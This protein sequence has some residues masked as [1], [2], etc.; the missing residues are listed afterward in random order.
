MHP[1]IQGR[2]DKHTYDDLTADVSVF[3]SRGGTIL[4]LESRSSFSVNEVLALTY[5]VIENMRR[6][7]PRCIAPNHVRTLCMEILGCNRYQSANFGL[8]PLD[9]SHFEEVYFWETLSRRFARKS[10]GVIS[11]AVSGTTGDSL[12]RRVEF[13]E[14]MSNTEISSV[15]VIEGVRS[16]DCAVWVRKKD[17][18][19]VTTPLFSEQTQ[20]KYWKSRHNRVDCEMLPNQQLVVYPKAIWAEMQKQAW[21]ETQLGEL[22]H[23]LNRDEKLEPRFC[24]FH[25]AKLHFLEEVLSIQREVER[26]RSIGDTKALRQE[27]IRLKT[28]RDVSLEFPEI[29]FF[30]E[31][32]SELEHFYDDEPTS[33]RR[34]H[35]LTQ[36]IGDFFIKCDDSIS[37]EDRN[38]LWG[39]FHNYNHGKHHFQEDYSWAYGDPTACEA[40]TKKKLNK[41]HTALLSQPFD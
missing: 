39:R 20:T 10:S 33:K 30:N 5:S 31:P 37:L 11:V 14:I 32:V 6:K 1:W 28:C 7:D 22:T 34:V 23:Y 41:A 9:Y 26:L 8:W 24:S 25:I 35:W 15:R 27:L 4:D 29:W 19:V 40:Y 16:N 13:A 3:W 21:F 2:L 38:R 36:N 17:G 18:A 12:F